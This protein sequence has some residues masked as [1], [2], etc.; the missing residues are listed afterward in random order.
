LTQLVETYQ[1]DQLI[2]IAQPTT[3]KTS[4]YHFGLSLQHS[5]LSS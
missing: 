1:F 5:N 4:W 2:A 3:L